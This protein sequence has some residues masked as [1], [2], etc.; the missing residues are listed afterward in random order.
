MRNGRCATVPLGNT[1]SRCPIRITGRVALPCWSFTTARRQLPALALVRTS[2]ATPWDSRKSR[3]D[4]DNRVDTRFV[5][6]AG[7]D[8]HDALEQRHHRVM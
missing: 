2:Q 6:T 1:V 4:R 3:K 8:V 7:V 5:V